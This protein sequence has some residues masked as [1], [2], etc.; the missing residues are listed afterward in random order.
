MYREKGTYSTV[1]DLV[2]DFRQALLR[3]IEAKVSAKEFSD[4][5]SRFS[6]LKNLVTSPITEVSDW[7]S[8]DLGKLVKMYREKGTY[9]TVVDLVPDFLPAF[10]RSTEP[11]VAPKDDGDA[12]DS[13]SAEDTNETDTESWDES[14]TLMPAPK[15]S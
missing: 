15:G 1:V 12:L 14:V 7:T 13:D 4:V 3:S 11:K 2:P 9:S 6:K 10:L 5:I 8:V